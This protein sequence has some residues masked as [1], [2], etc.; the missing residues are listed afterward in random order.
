MTHGP[1]DLLS[2]MRTFRTADG[3]SARALLT[4]HDA[5]LN[6]GGPDVA[7][8]RCV[9]LAH[10]VDGWRLTADVYAATGGRGPVMLFLHGGGWVGGSP[11]T[12]DRMSR[13][14]A[15]RGF[16]VISVDYP[17]APRRRFPAGYDGCLQALAWALLNAAQYGGD[18][19]RV[20]V[21]GDSAGANLAAAVAVSDE[22]QVVPLRAAALLYGIYD[23]HAALSVLAPLIGG[24]AS[25]TQQY[26]AP[27]SFTELRGDPRLSP[28][29]AAGQLP[30]CWLGV[31][32]D[33]P[34]LEESQALADE[35]ERVGVP[36]ELH[37]E[38]GAPH[39][40]LQMPFD[41]RCAAGLDSAA[42]FLHRYA[43][44]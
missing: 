8:E 18:A 27:G 34:L 16:L 15:V 13:E 33:D 12:H 28:L 29:H 26:V 21:A 25:D 20:V 44:A 40:Y 1:P 23:F 11:A 38:P 32:S 22:A 3:E 36:H 42:A 10:L 2:F 31:G 6:T 14:F 17:R 30:P 43:S 41:E 9:P 5:L 7:V 37:V 19:G 39:S 24:G 35:L 4:R